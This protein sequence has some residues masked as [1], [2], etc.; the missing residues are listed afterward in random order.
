[1]CKSG[2]NV[3]QKAKCPRHNPEKGWLQLLFLRLIHEKPM[4]GYQLMEELNKRG[5]VKPGTLETGTVYTVLR[6]M[7]NTG[8]LDS[9]WEEKQS[10][11]DRR[12]YKITQ[13][14]TNFLIQG[15]EEMV[16]R[17]SLVE[18]LALYYISNL[19]KHGE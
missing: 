14:G 13:A 5:Y 17:R 18:D 16:L 4:H 12:I 15:T 10:G 9:E 19:M 8:L 11:P 1:M 6:R 3:E 7:D 2:C